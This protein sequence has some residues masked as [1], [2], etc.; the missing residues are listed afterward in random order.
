MKVGVLYVLFKGNVSVEIL[1]KDLVQPNTSIFLHALS[2]ECTTKLCINFLNQFSLFSHL[3]SARDNLVIELCN[4]L[5]NYL[6][7][8]AVI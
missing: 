6:I 5:K 3:N 4:A 2:F 1:I 7:V 8:F